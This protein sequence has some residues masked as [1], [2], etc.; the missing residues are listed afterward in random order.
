PGG[1]AAARAAASYHEAVRRAKQ[2]ILREALEAAEGSCR[3]AAERLGLNRTYL[4][5]LINELDLRTRP[6]KET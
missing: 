2:R 3:L 6:A 5:R 4:H 1:P